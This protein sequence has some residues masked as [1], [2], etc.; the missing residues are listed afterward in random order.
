MKKLLNAILVF[1]ILVFA[2]GP[3]LKA[4]AASTIPTVSKITVK[5]ESTTLK[6]AYTNGDDARFTVTYSWKSGTTLYNAT[7][8]LQL[9]VTPA[10]RGIANAGS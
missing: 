5:A 2:L 9:K 6:D 1:A 10:N 7:N 3:A 8:P 4:E